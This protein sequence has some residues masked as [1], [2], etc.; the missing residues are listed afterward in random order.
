M[1]AALAQ[2]RRRLARRSD[3]EHGQALVR[4]DALADACLYA[5]LRPASATERWPL[6]RL[7]RPIAIGNGGALLLFAWIVARPRPSHL[8]RTLGMLSDDGLL[9]LAMT[10]FAAA[11]VCFYAVVMWVTRGNALRFGRHALHTA[12]AMAVLSFGATLANSPYGQQRIEFGIALL[13]ALVVIPLSLLWPMHDG[14][15]AA[16]RIAAYAHGADAA[17]PRSALSSSSKRPQV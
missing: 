2:L 8:R 10:W 17:G 12:V 4:V 1:R 16:A 15:D 11:M 7:L 5:G 9:S 14:A 3:S 6:Q 13:A